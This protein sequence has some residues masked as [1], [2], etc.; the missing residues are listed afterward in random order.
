M[1]YVWTSSIAAIPPAPSSP[2][3]PSTLETDPEE[4]VDPEWGLDQALRD[5]H[6]RSECS[7][8]ANVRIVSD[9]SSSQQLL[10]PMES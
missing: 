9:R 4:P 2:H 3:H 10:H 1:Y 6:S 7:M 8:Q 5:C